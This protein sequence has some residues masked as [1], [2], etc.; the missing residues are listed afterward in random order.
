M[1]TRPLTELLP[2]FIRW[3]NDARYQRVATI[4]QADGIIFLC[5]KCLEVNN[6]DKKGV[7]SIIC[8]KPR[9][10]QTT[11]PGPGRWN[12]NGTCFED[13]T[14]YAGSSSIRVTSG[15]R[16][17]GFIDKGIVRDV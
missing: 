7:H 11:L 13:L 17:H 6:N 8:W 4:E 1:K 14:L 2:E 15:C 5:P 10:P 12:F 3:I 16:W 9:I